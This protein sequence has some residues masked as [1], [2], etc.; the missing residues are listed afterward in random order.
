MRHQV[1]DKQIAD[2]TAAL[3]DATRRAIFIAVRESSE[4]LTVGMVAELFGI[5]RNLARHHLEKLTEDGFLL[6]GH[7]PTPHARK[8][9][10]PPKHY[11]ATTRP[12]QIS[13][14]TLRYD[15]L[16]DL[17]TK[18][19]DRLSPEDLSEVAEEVGRDYG[20]ELAAE[21]GTPEEAGYEEAVRGVVGAMS[22][23]GFAMN[24][25]LEAGH[26]LT[27]HCPFGEAAI[28]YPEVVCSLDRGI[29]SGLFEAIAR[30][31]ETV[32]H[33]HLNQLENCVTEIPVEITV[34]S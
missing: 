24:P 16:V 6:V 21:I 13:Y 30:G 34:R 32:L 4:A 7:Q 15:L 1:I 10:R 28:S 23:I 25:D 19:L 9:G 27:Y 8:A 11:Q 12:I 20:E 31:S 26:L 2:L 5:H 29:V 14:P 18:V 3:G 33:P 17:L 22:G